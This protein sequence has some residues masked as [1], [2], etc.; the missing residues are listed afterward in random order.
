MSSSLSKKELY[1]LTL[2]KL[3]ELAKYK[4]VINFAQICMPFATKF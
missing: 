2:A 3:K 1:V 4:M